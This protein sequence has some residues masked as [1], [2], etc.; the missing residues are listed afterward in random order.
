[1][2][3]AYDAATASLVNTS[4]VDMVLVGDSL[5]MVMLGRSGT[6]SVT[7]EEMTHHCAAVRCHGNWIC[8]VFVRLTL[9]DRCVPEPIDR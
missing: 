9:N 6:Q 5:G 3:T 2:V 4:S 8:R 7:L 1:M